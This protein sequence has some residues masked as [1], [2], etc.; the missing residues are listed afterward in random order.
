MGRVCGDGRAAARVLVGVERRGAE[1]GQ[2]T[3]EPESG[4]HFHMAA[5]FRILCGGTGS[6]DTRADT[7][8]DGIPDHCCLG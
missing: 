7:G 2:A 4:R 8:A 1:R 6:S 3:Q 5:E